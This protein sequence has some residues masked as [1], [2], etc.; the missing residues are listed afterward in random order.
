MYIYIHS[1]DKYILYTSTYNKYTSYTPI[2]CMLYSTI[3]C[4]IYPHHPYYT[5]STYTM[6]TYTGRWQCGCSE[7]RQGRPERVSAATRR[8]WQLPFLHGKYN[9][10][11][12]TTTTILNIA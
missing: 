10:Y 12:Y 5:Y 6:L 2:Y 7:H 4:T 8:M 3:L 11:Y 9:I 1:V